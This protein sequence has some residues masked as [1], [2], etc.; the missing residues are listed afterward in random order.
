MSFETGSQTS[1]LE[2][3]QTKTRYAPRWQVIGLNDDVT[4]MEYVIFLLIDVFH[5]NSDDAY[6]IM[7]DVHENGAAPFYFGTMEACELK[8]E[9]VK[10]MNKTYEENLQVTIEVVED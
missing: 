7:M 6:S 1:V 4:S 5:K 9:Q 10:T 2:D 3:T 8:V